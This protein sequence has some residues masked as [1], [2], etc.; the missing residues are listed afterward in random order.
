MSAIAGHGVYVTLRTEAELGRPRLEPRWCGPRCEAIT[1]YAGRR[2]QQ[3]G[4]FVYRPCGH[5]TQTAL[6]GTH[7]NELERHGSLEVIA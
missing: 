3:A 6:C 5:R 7:R 4:R 2:C 1:H